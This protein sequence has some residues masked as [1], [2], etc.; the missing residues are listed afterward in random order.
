MIRRIV[1]AAGTVALA[2]MLA[3]C[4]VSAQSEPQV[5]D[6]ADVPFGLAQRDR[7]T[8]TTLPKSG[9]SYALYFVDGDHLRSVTRT[10]PTP[11]DAITIL[12]TLVRGPDRSEIRD[13]LRTVL[14]PDL[15]IDHV[16]V[17]NRIATVALQGSGALN[18]SNDQ[19]ALGVAQMV[20]AMTDLAA[21]D[22]VR[23]EIDGKVAEIPRGDGTLS[24]KPVE[25]AD[26]PAVLS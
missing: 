3:A 26:Y 2:S 17:K 1:I 18:N 20:F 23:F 4:G 9:F 19:T 11:L 24:T 15:E 16:T 13:G 10:G 22:R 14:P 12:R 8:A 21:I 25:R 5:V 7:A 6:H